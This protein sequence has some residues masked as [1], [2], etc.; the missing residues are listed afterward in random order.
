LNVHEHVGLKIMSSYGV[1]V[2]KF[3]VASTVEDAV[4]VYDTLKPADESVAHDAVIKAQVLAG[5]R[6]LGAFK[7]GFQGGVHLIT[8]REQAAEFASKML[9]QTLV[10]KQTGED[11]RPCNEVLL[12][13][14]MYM[15][16]ELYFSIV[17]DRASAGPVLVAS[18]QGGTS[19]E[20]VAAATPEAIAKVPVADMAAGPT[21]EQLSDLSDFLGFTGKAKEEAIKT[22]KG[23]YKMFISTD[24]TLVE[25][26]PLAETPDGRVMVADAKI[27]FDDNAEYRQ[28]DIFNKRDTSQEDSREVEAAKHDLNY[29]G[30]DGSI[31]CMVNGAGLA[32]ATMDIIKLHGG[33]PANFLD[34]GG[35]ATA[36]QVTQAFQILNGD[37]RVKVILVNI[38][39]GIMRCDT[40]AQG[41]I[42]AASSIGLN[43]PLVV[44]LAGT[45]VDE[46]KKLIEE[47]GFRMVMTDD[48]DEA[49]HK[50]VKM[51]DIVD[52][53]QQIAMDVSFQ[54]P[55]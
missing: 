41:I 22:M 47:S 32:M 53:A 15:R 14:R 7:N 18:A 46:A 26:N 17:L 11:G 8:R 51:A 6:G 45:N 24:A 42:A 36:E 10:T 38:F 31:G 49:A 37:K 34:C 52:K 3:A 30:L 23:L 9:G 55:L 19:I 5:G 40:I 50:A 43:K 44:R 27:N 48:L 25:V 13:E 28:G 2:P 29:I 1:P 35:G 54:M 20:D 21:A 33:E 12:V 39:G 16:R 4:K